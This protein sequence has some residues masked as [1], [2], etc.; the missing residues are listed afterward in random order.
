MMRIIFTFAVIGVPSGALIALLALGIVVVHRGSGVVNF[1][2][3]AFAMIGGYIY[4][5][6]HVANGINF[7][8]R[9][10]L[11]VAFTGLIGALTHLLVM[12]PLRDAPLL[13]RIMAS[14]GVLAFLEQLMS[15]IVPASIILVSSEFPTKAYRIFGVEIGVNQIIITG[16]VLV[17][18][19]G[20]ISVYKYTQLGRTTT[21]ALENRR[22]ISS[23]GFSPDRIAATNWIIGG[24]LA[25]FAGILLAPITT[26][27]VSGY[28]LL[29]L[30]ALAAAVIG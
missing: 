13:S 10:I 7:V 1:A 26:L 24:C 8:I 21:A 27:S 17:L 5:W 3:G 4:Y 12:R 20:L 9:L 14:L 15:H 16:I 29:V 28:T 19:F 18:T 22:A 25:G 11:G 23:L 30:P 6:L 2:Q